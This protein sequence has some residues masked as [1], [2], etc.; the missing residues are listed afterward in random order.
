[1]LKRKTS[2]LEA[3]C[4]HSPFLYRAVMLPT[5]DEVESLTKRPR[6]IGIVDLELHIRGSSVKD[7]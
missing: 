2:S 6:V 3:L 4:E 7:L 1:M 5:M